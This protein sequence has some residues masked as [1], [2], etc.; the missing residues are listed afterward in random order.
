LEDRYLTLIKAVE[1]E[2]KNEE[3]FFVNALAT[4]SMKR[5]VELGFAWYPARITS[6]YYT[7][8]E[9]V[10]IEL[11]RIRDINTSHKLKTGL[12]VKIT[13]TNANNEIE[14][15]GTI[16]FLRKNKMKILLRVDVI[17]RDSLP[18]NVN[19]AIEMVYDERPY[20]IMKDAL[21]KVMDAKDGPIKSLR[22]GIRKLSLLDDEND[23]FVEREYPHLNPSQQLAVAKSLKAGQFA[24]IHGPPGTGK[25]TTLVSLITEIV[26][27]EKRVLV[28]APSNNATDLLTHLLDQVGLRVLRVGNVSRMDDDITHLTIDEKA[29]NH[30]EWQR[31][32]KVKIEAEEASKMASQF[33]RTFG[34]EQR[35]ERRDMIAESRELKKWARA[36]EEKLISEIIH[37]AQVILT[38]LVSSTSSIISDLRFKTV[39]IDEASQCLEPECWAAMLKAEKVVLAGDHKQLPPT[40]KSKGATALGLGETLLDRMS[41]FC[42]YSSLLNVQYRMNNAILEFP[43]QQFYGGKLIS[44]DSVANRSLPNDQKKVTFIDTAGTGFEE[45]FNSE[46]KSLWNEGEYF[47]IREHLLQSKE[48]FL[49]FEIGI[50]TPYAE[51]VRF[52]QSQILEDEELRILGLDVNSIDGFQGQEK[53]IIYISLVRSNDRS[54]IGFLV[55]E[56][57]LNVALTRAKKKLVVVGDSSTIGSHP[58]FNSLLNHIES[59]AHYQSAWEFMQ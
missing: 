38:T 51:Q 18:D 54:E 21:K 49:G 52:I 39:V 47:I 50:I 24:I 53:D 32:K 19:Y 16:S 33:K 41:D 22:E 7:I 56:R 43:N 6:K 11:E 9:N 30:N 20:A 37:D 42:K 31:I 23:Y 36:L 48:N 17:S 46:Y 2:R 26:K 45:K 28:C 55:D 35:A 57:R 59:K 27:K 3:A 13:T 29:R 1:E 58:I 8:G 34:N 4:Q 12:G 10:E 14:Y 25:T 15:F 5:K 40:V 44:H